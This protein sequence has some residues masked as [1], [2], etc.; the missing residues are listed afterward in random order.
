MCGRRRWSPE[1]V[2]LWVSTATLA[3]STGLLL[4]GRR[5]PPD[6]HQ[7]NDVISEVVSV[8]DLHAVRVRDIGSSIL[9][10][11]RI[12]DLGER[13]AGRLPRR[14]RQAFDPLKHGAVGQVARVLS[15]APLHERRHIA[16][17][18][19]TGGRKPAV[20]D[21]LV[22]PSNLLAEVIEERGITRGALC[23]CL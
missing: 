14:L 11:R 23:C 22:E 13:S 21:A 2:G 3:R 8:D 6:P 19:L 7:V 5:V 10:V 20:G 16:E 4:L 12:R 18:H 9:E 1:E 15:L 17:R